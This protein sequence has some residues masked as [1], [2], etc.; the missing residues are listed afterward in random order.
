MPDTAFRGKMDGRRTDISPEQLSTLAHR[1]ARRNRP[2]TIPRRGPVQDEPLSFAQQRLW[3]VHQLLP[4][5]PLYQ[6]PALLPFDSNV[7][8]EVLRNCLRELAERH[9]ILRTTFPEVAGSPVQRIHASLDLDFDIVD[10]C[11]LVQT[12]RQ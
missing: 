12:A 9:E 7:N 5:I 2:A 10:L 1:L 3:F 4:D 6:V 8:A 11:D